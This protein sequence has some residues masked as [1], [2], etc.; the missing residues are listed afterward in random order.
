M[1]SSSLI[2]L[3]GLPALLLALIHRGAWNRYSPKFAKNS[4]GIHRRLARSSLRLGLAVQ[5]STRLVVHDVTNFL[6]WVWTTVNS[7]PS[8]AMNM[9]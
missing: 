9:S 5:S 6:G 3:A 1:S 4:P 2:R 7:L 8:G